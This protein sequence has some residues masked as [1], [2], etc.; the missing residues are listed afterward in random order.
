MNGSLLTAVSSKAHFV[1]Y[2]H[3]RERGCQHY[4][5]RQGSNQ[6]ARISDANAVQDGYETLASCT[7]GKD[8][9]SETAISVGAQ[10]QRNATSVQCQWLFSSQG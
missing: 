5:D 1:R 6:D 2:E 7:C 8:A 10:W 9:A 4:R 3:V